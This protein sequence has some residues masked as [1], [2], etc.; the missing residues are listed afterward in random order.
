MKIGFFGSGVFSTALATQLCKYH[1]IEM[2]DKFKFFN[3]NLN[4]K[5]TLE[6]K[7][8]FQ[9]KFDII[10]IGI[11]SQILDEIIDTIPA[12]DAH[13]VIC[14]KGVSSKKE[15]FFT[16]ILKNQLK[17]D[18]ICALSGPNFATEIIQNIPT[19]TTV[20]SHSNTWI[21]RQR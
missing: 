15:I 21:G 17:H 5:Y 1:D 12:Y 14:T 10:F 19:I 2:Y 16:E 18:K 11:T 13:F 3:P 7:Q 4:A 6:V 8:F 20:A 9:S